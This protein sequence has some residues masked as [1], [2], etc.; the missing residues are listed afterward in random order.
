MLGPVDLVTGAETACAPARA[1]QHLESVGVALLKSCE[2][3]GQLPSSIP[4]N[5]V[6][7]RLMSERL[8]RV[9]GANCCAPRQ[10]RI[11]RARGVD[12]HGHPRRQISHPR[13]HVDS[14]LSGRR[15][16]AG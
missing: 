10:I 7:T 14:S 16:K 1:D 8:R 3:A 6:V 4:Q 12:E 2:P 5:R 13:P 9:Y 15:R 11:G